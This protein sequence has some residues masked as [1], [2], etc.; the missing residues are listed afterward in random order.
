MEMKD[1]AV[2]SMSVADAIAKVDQIDL[3]VEEAVIAI[4]IEV[5][6]ETRSIVNTVTVVQGLE[7]VVGK[8]V[9]PDAPTENPVALHANQWGLL[10]P[11]E[12]S[13]KAAMVGTEVIAKTAAVVKTGQTTVEEDE[14]SVKEVYDQTIV[15]TDETTLAGGRGEAREMQGH[16][17]IER[18]GPDDEYNLNES[19]HSMF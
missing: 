15:A 4:V 14:V 7:R 8:S 11:E 18:S 19:R 12:T 1:Q 16:R 10:L 9:N 13:Y 2:V 5:K 3:R 6:V 17:M